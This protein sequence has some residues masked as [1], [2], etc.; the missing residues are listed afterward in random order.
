MMKKE[1]YLKE[2]VRS[3]AMLSR[4]VEILN[5]VNLYDINIVAED[6]FTGL[7]N[8]IYGYKLRN[9]NVVEKNTPAID[10]GDE[11]NRISVSK[12]SFGFVSEKN[13]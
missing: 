10:L 6:F 2:I 12:H 5:S 1:I 11:E 9:L 3:L 7:L 13:C 4:E 8:L